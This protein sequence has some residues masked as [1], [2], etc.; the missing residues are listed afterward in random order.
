MAC[1]EQNAALHGACYWGQ[2]GQGPAGLGS[3]QRTGAHW[4][5]RG[6]PCRLQAAHAQAGGLG[7]AALLCPCPLCSAPATCQHLLCRG[8]PYLSVSTSLAFPNIN[9]ALNQSKVHQAKVQGAAS[10][11]DNAPVRPD[12]E[13]G[14][15]LGLVSP[16]HRP[17]A[18]CSVGRSWKQGPRSSPLGVLR[19]GSGWTLTSV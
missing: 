10:T 12:Q 4:V 1:A 13:V 16:G 8:R 6:R 15:A 14:P 11:A 19:A 3:S 9:P 2:G 7:P 18:P 5:R 17:F